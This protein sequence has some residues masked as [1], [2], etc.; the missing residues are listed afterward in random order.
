M[1]TFPF[2]PS[3]TTPFQ[4]QP[5][6]DGQV[7]TCTV[8]ASLWEQRY[9]LEVMTLG[10]VLIVFIPM[11]GSPPGYDI[12]LVAGYFTTSS[13]VWRPVDNQFIVTP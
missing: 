1:T 4:F 12:N 7:Y 3:S 8:K 5:T 10:G 6:L 2:V 13:I 9:Y 11:V